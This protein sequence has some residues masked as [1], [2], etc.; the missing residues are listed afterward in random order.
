MCRLRWFPTVRA[1]VFVIGALALGMS[2][3]QHKSVDDYL[4]AGDEALQNT[5]MAD[6]ERNYQEA[7]KLAPDD[8][9]VHIAL[10]NFYV[11][12]QKAGQ[13]K[14]EF[15]K[16]LDLAPKNA[17][18]HAALGNLYFAQS[19]YPAAENQYHA[20]VALQPDR[21][22]YQVKLAQA[23]TKEHKLA[24]AEAALRT[25]I[26]LEP[27]NAVAHL[28]LSALLFTEPNRQTEA[29]AEYAEAQALNPSLVAATPQPSP[30]PAAAGNLPAP[31]ANAAKLRPLDKRFLLTHDSPVYQGPDQASA[32]VAH[33]HHKKLVR[34]TG[35]TGDWLQIKLKD[36][37]V[38]FIPTSAAE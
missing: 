37:T 32:V 13:A 26:G 9:R 14:A 34:V 10:G 33:V 28:A 22:E 21:A 38:G 24:E 36:G 30:T 8:P 23:L 16:V 19:Q 18:A 3:C 29:Q 27:K 25:A 11:Y 2:G 15:M 4:N 20:A 31:P 5:K 17:A 6:A 12:E 35:I 1:A 7:A